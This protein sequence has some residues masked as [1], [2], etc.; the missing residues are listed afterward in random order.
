MKELK[1]EC[2]LDQLAGVTFVPQIDARSRKL[3]ERRLDSSNSTM[4]VD[5][6]RSSSYTTGGDGSN[7]N[8]RV[9]ISD[10]AGVHNNPMGQRTTTTGGDMSP[11]SLSDVSTRLYHDAYRSEMRKIALTKEV[12]LERAAAMEPPKV[13]KGRHPHTFFFDSHS[14]L[15]LT[16]ALTIL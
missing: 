9:N 11:D 14:Y 5:D 6:S 7:P 15:Y 4:M 13:S 3:A 10:R 16:R 12:E 8:I 1:K 2:E